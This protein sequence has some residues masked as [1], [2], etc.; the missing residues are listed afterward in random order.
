[1]KVVAQLPEWADVRWYQDLAH[2]RRKEVKSRWVIQ[3]WGELGSDI[4]TAAERCIREA[5]ITI[6]DSTTHKLELQAMLENRVMKRTFSSLEVD[7][8]RA[9]VAAGE[10]QKTVAVRFGISTGLCC[11]IIKGDI[12]NPAWYSRRPAQMSSRC[13]PQPRRFN[14]WLT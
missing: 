5:L 6:S 4:R 13:H 3:H 8:I 10:M 12:W 7:Q 11:Q 14:A 1:V 9:A 2:R